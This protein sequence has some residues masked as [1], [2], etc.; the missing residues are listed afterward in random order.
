MLPE[1]AL[2]SAAE[3]GLGPVGV[4]L[5]AVLQGLAEFLPISSSGHL[6]LARAAL[7]V[8]D[9]GLALDVALH[10]GTLAA[11]VFAYRREVAQL[12]ADLRRAS[13]HM[14]V[15]LA[16]GTL[17]AAVVGLTLREFFRS[18]ALSTR[19]A[20]IG[21]L[22]TAVL[23][24]LGEWGRRRAA[25]EEF[26]AS[27]ETGYGSPRWSDALLLG[28]AQA[29]ALL[30]GVSRSGSTIA[31]GLVRGMS[32]TQAARLSFLLSIPAV[33]GAAVLELPA[34]FEKGIGGLSVPM[35]V[36]AVFVAGMVGWAALRSLVLTLSKGA[37]VW[38]ALYCSVLGISALLFV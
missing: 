10:L 33:L 34:A 24:T 20:G 7:G 22:L 13:W 4:L 2:E 6:V 11:V 37:F 5:L 36:G 26:A 21:L 18:A 23:L 8:R 1:I 32:V 35:L 3:S 25:S 29:M 14:W 19:S 12:L 9:A 16:L 38:F 28:A 30:P 17:P 31:M 15:W 27:P